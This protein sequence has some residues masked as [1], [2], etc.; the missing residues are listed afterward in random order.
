MN[1][2]RSTLL[3]DR[4][5]IAGL[6]RP[7]DYLAAVREG[8]LAGYRGQAN[9]PPPLH[10]PGIGGGFHAKGAFLA[11]GRKVVAVK[12]NGNFPGNPERTGLPTIQGAVLLCDAEDGRLLA[13]L[14]SIELTLRRTAAASALAAEHLARPDTDTL[15]LI[16][17]GG[18]ARAQVEALAEVLPLRRVLAW[19]ADPGKARSFRAAVAE[20]SGLDCAVADRL[21]AATLAAGAIVTCTT[22]QR[23]FLRPEHVARGTFI[24]AVGADSPAKAEIDPAL[25]AQAAVVVDSLEQC[26]H[27]GDLRLAVE[28]G[29]VTSAHVRGELGAL[30]AGDLAGRAAPDE[31]WLF[32]ST[33]TA[34]QD[35]ASAL[36]VYDKACAAGAGTGFAFA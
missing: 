31:I 28:T 2:D 33:G 27:M 19:D 32:D 13:V 4:A 12:L 35:V 10:V 18:Q 17:C 36:T 29:A 34:L 25:T 5:T 6:M 30:V 7:A 1:A 11:A 14:D 20:R 3:L 16:G 15:A 26:L 8:F 21:E 22:A 23:P 24:A 9:A